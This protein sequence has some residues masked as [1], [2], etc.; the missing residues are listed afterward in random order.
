[1]ATST[2][3]NGYTNY[4]TWRIK[5]EI[6]PSYE[7]YEDYMCHGMDI[8]EVS[9]EIEEWVKDELMVGSDLTISYANAFLDGV[10]WYEI[11]ETM[12]LDWQEVVCKNCNNYTD[13]DFCGKS[14]KEEYGLVI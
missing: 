3:H 12:Y 11:A 2:K 1:M 10:N 5:A 8:F 4:A 14:C 7:N 6:F 9:S 13:E